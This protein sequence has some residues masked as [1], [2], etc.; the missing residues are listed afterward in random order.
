MF[1]EQLKMRPLAARYVTENRVYRRRPGG[2]MGKHENP[3]L[4]GALQVKALRES[5]P[6]LS[7]RFASKKYVLML[8]RWL[9]S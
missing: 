3:S 5:L 9:S 1:V 7:Q 2:K 4:P 6:V 8:E